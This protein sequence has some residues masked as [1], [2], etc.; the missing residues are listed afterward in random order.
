[1]RNKGLIRGVTL[2]THPHLVPRL[3]TVGAIPSLPPCAS[4]A[5]SGTALLYFFFVRACVRVCV[6]GGERL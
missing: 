4:M 3:R 1:V 6:G 5:C 2:T